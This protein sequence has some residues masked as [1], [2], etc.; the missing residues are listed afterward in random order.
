MQRVEEFPG[1]LPP[2]FSTGAYDHARTTIGYRRIRSANDD[3]PNNY[4]G[5]AFI[6]VTQGEME[7]IRKSLTLLGFFYIV[8]QP[9]DQ[10]MMR[11]LFALRYEV[12]SGFVKE[13]SCEIDG[14]HYT[15]KVVTPNRTMVYLW[16]DAWKYGEKDDEKQP[17]PQLN[18]RYVFILGHQ[19]V[20][21][22]PFL[23][24]LRKRN[25]T[26][27]LV[28]DSGAPNQTFVTVCPRFNMTE[29]TTK[30]VIYSLPDLRQPEAVVSIVRE[31]DVDPGQ[32]QNQP[33][34][35]ERTRTHCR[36]PLLV[37]RPIEKQQTHSVSSP[38]HSAPSSPDTK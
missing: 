28:L 27:C 22:Q 23:P 4:D 25:D 30:E 31:R 18:R 10:A 8:F 1:A 34:K 17:L 15:L 3:D 9:T 16:M 6:C 5:L 32:D 14:I 11:R 2:M 20:Q 19:Q 29:I 24:T 13:C 35:R 21:H 37:T 26:Q 38:L 7:G 36:C 12:Y 33:R